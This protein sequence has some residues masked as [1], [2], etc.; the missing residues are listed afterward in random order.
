[1]NL[2][3]TLLEFLNIFSKTEETEF[4]WVLFIYFL[5]A[6]LLL[7]KTVNLYGSRVQTLIA[8]QALFTLHSSGLFFRSDLLHFANHLV[9]KENNFKLLHIKL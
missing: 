7:V 2:I 1:M 9:H 3:M 4:K 5:N 6:E 8:L